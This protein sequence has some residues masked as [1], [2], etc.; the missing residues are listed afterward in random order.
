MCP[1]WSLTSQKELR[2][3]RFHN[4]EL[5]KIFWSKRQVRTGD[6]RKVPNEEF[7]DLYFSPNI[8]QVI[9][10]RRIRWGDHAAWGRRE[11]PC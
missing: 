5:R 8:T 6:W 11:R 7:Q 3:R 2:L 4:R 9:K 10:S 1:A